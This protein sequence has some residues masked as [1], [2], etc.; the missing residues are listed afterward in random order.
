MTNLIKLELRK[1]RSVL[2]ALL[3]AFAVSFVGAFFWPDIPAKH[4]AKMVLIIW[5]VFGFPLAAL[6]FGASAGA[7]LRRREN[8]EA[9]SL[10]PLSPGKRVLAALSANAL[11][12]LIIVVPILLM[13]LPI[14]ANDPDTRRFPFMAMYLLSPCLL[15]TAFTCAYLFASAVNGGALA[16]ALLTP[17]YDFLFNTHISTWLFTV[18]YTLAFPP[19]FATFVAAFA[20][21]ALVLGYICKK[22]ADKRP[23]GAI[24]ITLVA[25][26]LLAADVMAVAS[27]LYSAKHLADKV[28]LS[29]AYN[30]DR[31]SE[32][33]PWKDKLLTIKLNGEI[34]CID[35][36]GETKVLLP[37]WHKVRFGYFRQYEWDMPSRIIDETTDRHGLWV[38]FQ[39]KKL[40]NAST[41][42]S[43]MHLIKDLSDELSPDRS[44]G[45]SL[46]SDRNIYLTEYRGPEENIS[47]R[48]PPVGGKKLVWIT[49]KELL[50]KLTA[51]SKKR[52]AKTE[53]IES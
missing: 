34:G 2:W 35:G 15:L 37:G 11:W 49:E 48:V 32:P 41:P 51:D 42:D 13:A 53:A 31:G 36:R 39:N 19:N 30:Y 14:L 26:G 45:L 24:G 16:V 27:F 5:S 9:E 21:P 44:Y 50:A 6:L 18:H 7:E 1:N 25:T 33:D 3:G 43:P 28:W 23:L 22:A 52:Q 38:L 47:A 20:G 10:L 29:H 46:R 17:I 40:Y 4:A 12:T 8:A